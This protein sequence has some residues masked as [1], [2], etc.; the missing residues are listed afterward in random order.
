MTFDEAFKILYAQGLAS[1]VGRSKH[2]QFEGTEVYLRVSPFRIGDEER[3]HAVV[4]ASIVINEPARYAKGTTARLVSTIRMHTDRYILVEQVLT[5]GY[6]QSLVRH[7]FYIWKR[8]LAGVATLI[9]PR[10]KDWVP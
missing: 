1:I 2:L 3:T 7:G 6:E 9:L 4:I 10:E 8:D 5:K